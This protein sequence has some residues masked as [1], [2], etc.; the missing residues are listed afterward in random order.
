MRIFLFILISSHLLLAQSGKAKFDKE[1]NEIFKSKFFDTTLAAV[2]IYDLTAQK[3][4]FQRNNKLL[5]HPASNMKILT[6]AAA[7]VFLGP[8]Y[9]FKTRLYYDGTIEDSVLKGNLYVQGG[10]DPDFAPSD[11]YIF[12]SSLRRKGIKYIE[13]NLYADISMKDSLFWGEGWMW[14]DDQTTDAP[15]LSSLNLNKNIISVLCQPSE[16]DKPALIT[17]SPENNLF[18]IE[19]FTTTV[20]NDTIPI[21]VTREFAG[22]KNNIIIKGQIGNKSKTII[23]NITVEQPHL[24]F[25]NVLKYKLEENEIVLSGS[26]DTARITE[27]AQ[28]LST[29]SRKLKDDIIEDLNKNSDNLSAEMTLAALA[30][31]K[32]ENLSTAKKGILLIDSL[33]KLSGFKPSN[34]RIVDGSG[35]SHYNLVSAE[36]ILGIL[37]FMYEKKY[38]LF[39]ILK[40]SFPVGGV[41]GT[42]KSRMKGTTAEGIVYAKTGTLSGISCLSG[43]VTTKNGNEIAFSIMMQNHFGKTRRAHFFQDK[44]CELIANYE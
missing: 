44:I 25:L 30:S 20:V 35:V 22:K 26:I 23:K 29:V 4:L 43:Y 12:I 42:L 34:Y 17:I 27:D 6:T 31:L 11:L 21:Q 39:E 24:Y 14:D 8:E 19:N 33:I 37:K 2:D 5:L 16:I 32:S 7:L 10:C 1:L 15:Y 18:T 38:E 41:D 40:N 13:G 9:K 36:L 28:L 3:K